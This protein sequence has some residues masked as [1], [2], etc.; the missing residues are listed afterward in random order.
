MSATEESALEGGPSRGLAATVARGSSW[1]I[2][3]QVAPLVVNIVLTPVI[4]SGLGI[5]RYGLFLLINVVA[6]VLMCLDG[7]FGHAALRYFPIYAGTDDRRAST[8]LLTSML[9]SAALITAVVF[10]GLWFLAPRGMRLFSIPDELYD[11]GVFLMR[12]LLVIVVMGLMRVQFYAI[13]VAYQRFALPN[14]TSMLGHVVYAVGT[15]LTVSHGWGLYGMG[16]TML[17]QQVLPTFLLVPTA[18]RYLTASAIGFISWGEFKHF[19]RYALQMQWTNLMLLGTQHADGLLV[20]AFLPVRQVAYYGAGANFALQVRNV[21]FN[22]LV[23]VQSI[24]G[25]SVGLRGE[26]G[27]LPDF[28]RLQRLWIIAVTGYGA[29]AMAAA[30]FGITSWLGDD[31]AI[32]GAVAVIMLAA[33]LASL[34]PGVLGLWTQVLG[35]PELNARAVSLAAVV[36]ILLTLVLIGPFGIIGTVLATAVSQVGFMILLIRLA[37]SRLPVPVRGVLRDVPVVPALAAALLVVALELVVRP[38]LPQG[39]LGLVLVGLTAAPGLLLYAVM[40]F[41][42]R[43]IRSFVGIV[44]SRL[45]GRG[46]AVAADGRV[47]EPQ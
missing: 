34:L 28:E 19:G 14:V 21:P 18:C 44:A 31:F 32:S 30:W 9:T 45:R 11:E 4:I 13:L 36:N 41:G 20:G 42:P 8:R 7:G 12:A 33:S 5:D 35:R 29:V 26:Q 22:A 39:P 6:A 23:P 46:S 17:A 43:K 40:T 10:G 37:R 47:S 27:A 25:R 2:A 3:A 38:Y 15:L 16:W 24:L 1:Q